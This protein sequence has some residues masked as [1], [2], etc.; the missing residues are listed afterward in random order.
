MIVE[1]KGSQAVVRDVK[2]ETEVILKKLGIEVEELT[3]NERREFKL[4]GG[5]KVI[6][7]TEGKI[8]ELT[9]IKKGFVIT[10][11]NEKTV[12][13]KDE[14]IRIL[15]N[16]RGQVMIEGTYPGSSGSYYYGFNL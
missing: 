7:I 12:N 4:Q 11:V 3:A 6:R 16:T 13:T 10:R 1:L 8:K 2:K 5:L 9:N 14:F 15:E